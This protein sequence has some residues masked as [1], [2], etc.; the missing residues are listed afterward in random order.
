MFLSQEFTLPV[1]YQDQH[2]R[3]HRQ[4]TMRLATALDEIEPL[5]D[6]RVQ[7]NEAAFGLLLLSRVVT[8]LGTLT[9]VGPEIIGG[10]YAADFAYLQELYMNLNAGNF[11]PATMSPR[12]AAP[13]LSLPQQ[14]ETTCPNCQAELLLDL[15]DL[16]G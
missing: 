6:P 5:A 3:L 13:S 15:S 12:V 11:A 1:G 8:R 2:G 9:P 10:L 16:G 4:G 14:V 7:A